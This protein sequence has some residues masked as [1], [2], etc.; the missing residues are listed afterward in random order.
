M[1]TGNPKVMACIPIE[2]HFYHIPGS[3]LLCKQLL[4]EHILLNQKLNICKRNLITYRTYLK[5]ITILL[6]GL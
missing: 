3:K 4:V 2:N 6:N 1:S 5:T